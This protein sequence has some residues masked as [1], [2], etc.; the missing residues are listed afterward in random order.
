VT[1]QSAAPAPPATPQPSSL[2]KSLAK[3]TF[4]AVVLAAILILGSGRAG[5]FRAWLFVGL[6][7]AAQVAVGIVV[8]RISPDLLAER[9]R[10]PKDTESW[11]KVAVFV[12]G[13][14][15]PLAVWSAAA[16]DMRVHWPPGVPLVW[17]LAAFLVC[18]LGILVTSWAM[19]ANRFFTST[20]R[21]QTERGHV[22]VDGGPYRYVRHPG[23]CGALVFTVASPVALGS[24]RA[25]IPAVLTAVALIIRTALED[26]TLRARLPG[27]EQY[28]RRTSSRLLPWLW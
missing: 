24:W 17:S 22:V 12:V 21:I 3:Y 10:L 5:W 19:A 23:Y 8:H 14:I 11:D 25:L 27:Y 26:R 6:M 18:L 15:G 9:S 20:V 7:F 28:A 2:R 4:M 1:P 16:W 13:L